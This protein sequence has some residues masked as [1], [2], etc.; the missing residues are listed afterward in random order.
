MNSTPG[1]AFPQRGAA[2]QPAQEDGGN[3]AASGKDFE[4]F[5]VDHFSI[6]L[7]DCSRIF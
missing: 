7:W 2:D 6:I 4:D 5:Q 1:H 3:G